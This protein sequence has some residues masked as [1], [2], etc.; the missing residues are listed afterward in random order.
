[1]FVN[2][3]A[4]WL[5]LATQSAQLGLD[6]QRVIGLRMMRLAAGGAR[7]EIEAQRMVAE[8]SAAFVEAQ[9]TLATSLATGQGHHAAKKILRGYGRKVRAN[10]RRL[11]RG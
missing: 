4:P 1:M 3:F 11:S 6:A 5:A 10:H 7:A 2:P 8:K 9:M